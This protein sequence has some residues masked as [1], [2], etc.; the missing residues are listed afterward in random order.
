[1][2]DVE[3]RDALG[4]RTLRR[5]LRLEPDEHLPR[6]DATA[7]AAA[8]ERR[9]ALEQALRVTRG[10]ALVGVGLGLEAVIALAAFRWLADLDPIGL[11]GVGL[12]V[13]AAVAER[14][15]PA[16]ALATDPAVLTA[17]LAAV[18]FATLYERGS[19]GR[20]SVSVRAS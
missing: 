19:T 20:E 16:A 12:S 18:V 9:T 11:L 3:D 6:L 17:T 13:M 7:I 10:L 1:M 4:E 15:V 14:L 2:N 5:A 8:A